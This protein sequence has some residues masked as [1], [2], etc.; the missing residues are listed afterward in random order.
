MRILGDYIAHSPEEPVS[1]LVDFF[2]VRRSKSDLQ[3]IVL[4]AEGR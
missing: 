4:M 2:A 3:K 1:E